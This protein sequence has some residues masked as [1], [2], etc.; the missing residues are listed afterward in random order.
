MWDEYGNEALTVTADYLR[1]FNRGLQANLSLGFQNATGTPLF[2][3]ETSSKIDSPQSSQL[4]IFNLSLRA[5]HYV[6]LH[7]RKVY[8]TWGVGPALYWVQE[9]AELRVLSLPGEILI[10]ERD[11]ILNKWRVGGDLAFGID[12][13]FHPRWSIGART[14]VYWIPWS[15]ESEMSLTTDFIGKRSLVGYS[16]GF[17]INYNVF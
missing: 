8:F 12:S 15:S 5:G 11:E 14:R 7:D 4:Q 9:S 16:F 10:E 13:R 6:D 2:D 1:M 3:Y 17:V